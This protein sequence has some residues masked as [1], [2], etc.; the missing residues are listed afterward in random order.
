MK[1]VLIVLLIV[2]AIAGWQFGQGT[3]Q[4]G[5]LQDTIFAVI[6]SNAQSDDNMIREVLIAR[7]AQNG[8][9]LTAADIQ[10]SITENNPHGTLASDIVGQAGIPLTNRRINVVATQVF[11]VLGIFKFSNKA[12]A[13]KIFTSRAQTGGQNLPE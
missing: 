8:I 2:L 10:V 4:Y 11:Y 7:A 1:Y 13:E 3:V 6:D 5:Y 12:S 9:R